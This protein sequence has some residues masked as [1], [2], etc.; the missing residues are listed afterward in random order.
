MI[1]LWL[2]ASEL[3]HFWNRKGALVTDWDKRW[4]RHR[5]ARVACPKPPAGHRSWLRGRRRSTGILLALHHAAVLVRAG[6]QRSV[7]LYNTAFARAQ[8]ISANP[9]WY[10]K[11]E[12][13]FGW[14][15]HHRIAR[16]VARDTWV[17]GL[18]ATSFAMVGNRLRI[19]RLGTLILAR[20][21]VIA[22]PPERRRKKKP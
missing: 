11:E 21:G 7:W 10:P 15:Q 6:P 9:K 17:A 5:Y 18:H 14:L 3:A 12:V 13:F 1:R 16:K 22:E 8:M 19:Y 2:K 20:E 4:R